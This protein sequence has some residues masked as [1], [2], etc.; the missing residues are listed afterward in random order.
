MLALKKGEWESCNIKV[1]EKRLFIH[2]LKQVRNIV[3][4]G[5][6]DSKK[7]CLFKGLRIVLRIAWAEKKNISHLKV[8]LEALFFEMIRANKTVFNF[9]QGNF[10]MNVLSASI[11]VEIICFEHLQQG[12]YEKLN[13]AIFLWEYVLPNTMQVSTMMALWKMVTGFRS[14]SWNL[15]YPHYV[16]YF[17]RQSLQKFTEKVTS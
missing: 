10:T 1:V 9:Q 5:I 17:V 15:S 3:Y 4:A 2:G 16:T 6:E 11:S 13:P 7:D 12:S 14:S 8:S